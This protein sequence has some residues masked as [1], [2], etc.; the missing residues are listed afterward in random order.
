M[1]YYEVW[2]GGTVVERLDRDGLWEGDPLTL[3]RPPTA[4]EVAGMDTADVAA[5]LADADNTSRVLLRDALALLP[6]MPLPDPAAQAD[7]QAQVNEALAAYRA[8]GQPPADVVDLANKVSTHLQ[9]NA[10]R[11]ATEQ[12][13]AYSAA[14]AAFMAGPV[15]GLPEL[16]EQSKA[17]TAQL[18]ALRD[19]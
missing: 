10:Y 12:R 2:Q 13:A 4:M 16:I 8:L 19:A 11:R 5:E 9:S 17:L 18:E 3:V 14:N 1:S 6:S 7:A 15:M